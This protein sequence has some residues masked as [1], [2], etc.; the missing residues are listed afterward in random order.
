MLGSHV[1]APQLLSQ[2]RRSVRIL[3]YARTPVVSAPLGEED[4]GTPPGERPA[5]SRAD[6]GSPARA[7]DDGHAP[8]Q[9]FFWI[10]A[11]FGHRLSSGIRSFTALLSPDWSG[12]PLGHFYSPGCRETQFSE[13]NFRHEFF[14]ETR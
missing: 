9:P 5:D 13:T 6:S 2:S 12:F 1:Q 4:V 10:P 7:C 8:P 3:P 11:L 14:S